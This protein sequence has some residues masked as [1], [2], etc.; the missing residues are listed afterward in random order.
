M[1]QVIFCLFFVVFAGSCLE[2]SFQS[3]LPCFF[4]FFFSNNSISVREFTVICNFTDQCVCDGKLSD[5]VC[6]NFHDDITKSWCEE[7]SWI[8][9]VFDLHAECITEGHLGNSCCNT[10]TIQCVS[11]NNFSS[12]DI[13]VEFF[14]LIHDSCVIRKIVLITR[15]AEPYKFV[16][17][18]FEFRCDHILDLGYVYCKGNKCWRHV[19]LIEGTGHTV[20]TT[21]GRK[22]ESHLC[23]IG[24]KECGEWLAPS[25]W[26][27][28]HTT[29]VF[30][31]C[32]ADL[33]VITT[34]SYD[35]CY[36]FCY[37]VSSSVIWTPG[38]EIWIK[39]VTHHGNCISFS[40]LYRNF[41]NHALCF[42]KLILT[43]VWHKY[44]ACTDRTVEHFNE[45]FL[46]AYVE[47]SKCLQ[48][49]CLNI[50]NVWSFFE[51]V[52]VFVRDLNLYSCFLMCTVGIKECTGNVND[53]FASP[54]KNKTWLF[55][56][57]CNRDCF[58]V[59]FVCKAKEFV[60]I[61]WIYNNCHTLLGF[62]D[63]DLCSVKAGI[64]FRNFVKV[65]AKS[66]CKLTDG[67]GYT[68]CTKVV[69]F[70]DDV[71]DFFTS[72]HTLD[73]TL[74]RCVTFL[75][76]CTADFD[77]SLCVYLGG[78]CCTTDTVTAGT[79]S[80]KD[81]DISRIGVFT[82]NGT[83]RSCTHNG[84]DLHTFCNVVRMIDFFD[85]AGS[86]ADLVTI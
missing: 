15:C 41:C 54:C 43:T 85:I 64:F 52:S 84:T 55:G 49:F 45:A 40:V 32:E 73:L 56:N 24:T 18:F 25:L 39:A 72:E 57:D 13:I 8:Q 30:L 27:F 81:D 80:Q 67:N 78:T 50:D 33:L 63:C 7:V 17:C 5:F 20:F 46:G 38:R 23:C 11:G 4:S 34:C 61:F 66:I 36:R 12:L 79:S 6:R 47:V 19:D 86:Q 59:F 76:F 60:N 3:S 28:G 22:S 74:C 31:E 51:K 29:E 21:D 62:R 53:L 10:M 9:V 37:C 1:V 71:A 44:A 26:I 14:V 58:E 69:T 16:S 68:A 65:Y 2:Y 75:Y 35:S 82:D 70:F 42:C 48:P 77:G 83:S